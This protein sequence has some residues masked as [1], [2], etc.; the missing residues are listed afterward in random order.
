MS[1]YSFPREGS[2]S[3]PRWYER[4]NTKVDVGDA[5]GVTRQ[6]KSLLEHVAQEPSV[7]TT[8]IAFSSLTVEQ[9]DAVR[10]DTEGRYYTLYVYSF[11]KMK[12][13]TEN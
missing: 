10:K 2:M 7:G 5:I 11:V 6:H 12:L 13:N 9:Q 3:N 8:I 1:F 4:F